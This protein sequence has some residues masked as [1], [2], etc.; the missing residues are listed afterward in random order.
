MLFTNFRLYI[1]TAPK[2]TPPT[3]PHLPHPLMILQCLWR[4]FSRKSWS[5]PKLVLRKGTGKG[6]E[7]TYPLSFI[8]ISSVTFLAAILTRAIFSSVTSS[9]SSASEMEGAELHIGSEGKE[10]ATFLLFF[11]SI[12]W[13]RHLMVKCRPNIVSILA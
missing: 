6:K 11:R 7:K 4:I 5:P 12:S 1:I 2:Y 13:E 8:V 3:H 10:E 9:K